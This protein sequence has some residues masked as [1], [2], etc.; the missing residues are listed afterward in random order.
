M[1]LFTSGNIAIT[2]PH[3]Y[4]QVVTTFN[5]LYRDHF[6]VVN[7]EYSIH[8]QLVTDHEFEKFQDIRFS[9]LNYFFI[10]TPPNFNGTEPE[11]VRY[12]DAIHRI[13]EVH[14]DR[15]L[16][17]N[18]T[19]IEA[20]YMANCNNRYTSFNKSTYFKGKISAYQLAQLGFY[21]VGDKNFPGKLRCSFCRR[22]INIFTTNDAA[23]LEIEFERRIVDF[24]HRHT[25]LSATCPFSIDL[26]G[27]NVKFT[28]EELVKIIEL[29]VETNEIHHYNFS[30]CLFPNIDLNNMCQ[31]LS[32]NIL[33]Q[34]ENNLPPLIDDNTNYYDLMAQLIYTDCSF[35]ESEN[36]NSD[37]NTFDDSILIFSPI[38]YYIG[39]EPKHLE[40]NTLIS[41]IDSYK[42]LKWEQQVMSSVSEN[43]NI[44]PEALARAGFFYTGIADNV[45]CF[46][47]GLGLN[48]WDPN[49]DPINEHVRFVPRCT[50][51][52]RLFGRHKVKSIYLQ[53][54]N[55]SEAQNVNPNDGNFFNNIEDIHGKL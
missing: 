22:T 17:V 5:P 7:F 35:F 33:A 53:T 45:T 26:N 19:D 2:H 54:Q 18:T 29:F 15:G 38:D 55:I 28:V 44:K 24:L 37:D 49:D 48:H 50:W 10:V 4:T 42:K 14:Y 20:K 41:R 30:L 21:F 39:A 1:L 40:Y 13:R 25:H 47:C 36:L 27:D 32:D 11:Q 12:V 9:A 31:T 23:Y 8:Q 3:L 16:T 6:K 34:Y 46:W 51:L 43:S 52:V